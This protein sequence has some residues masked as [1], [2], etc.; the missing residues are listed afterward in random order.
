MDVTYR[1]VEEWLLKYAWLGTEEERA[2]EVGCIMSQNGWQHVDA[3]ADQYSGA[4]ESP[5]PKSFAEGIE[6]A[7][8]ELYE[9][10]TEP[11]LDTCPRV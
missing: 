8:S 9:C 4:Q 1:N 7:L 3:R 11:H 10:H 2:R 6:F 5:G